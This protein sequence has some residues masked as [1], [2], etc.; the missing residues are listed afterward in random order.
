[1]ILLFL[2]LLHNAYYLQKNINTDCNYTFYIAVTFF[3][4]LCC[5][6]HI[7]VDFFHFKLNLKTVRV[8]YSSLN[9]QFY[10]YRIIT[11]N[12]MYKNSIDNLIKL[13]FFAIKKKIDSPKRWRTSSWFRFQ[14]IH[15]SKRDKRRIRK[16]RLSVRVSL[17]PLPF[18]RMPRGSCQDF[19]GTKAVLAARMVQT[20]IPWRMVS[21]AAIIRDPTHRLEHGA[22]I[23]H[24]PSATNLPNYSYPRERR[25]R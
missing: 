1:M 18:H 25:A 8:R 4:S 5:L 11:S 10:F 6:Y 23:V 14:K 20:L 16:L 2:P 19:T 24:R 15:F 17:F 7:F 21:G 3:I 9:V 13:S 12:F 22:N